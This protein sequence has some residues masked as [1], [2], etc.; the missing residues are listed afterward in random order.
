MLEF[1]SPGAQ[2]LKKMGSGMEP[3]GVN[4]LGGCLNVLKFQSSFAQSSAENPPAPLPK[5]KKIRI[6][7]ITVVAKGK[8]PQVLKDSLHFVED[9][10]YVLEDS[11]YVS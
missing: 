7:R 6:P 8:L 2:K 3:L 4:F 11:L 5:S 1:Q 10:S 9:S